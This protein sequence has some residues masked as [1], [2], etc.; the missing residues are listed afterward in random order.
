MRTGSSEETVNTFDTMEIR[1]SAF[2]QSVRTLPIPTISAFKDGNRIA[3]IKFAYADKQLFS[4]D[5]RAIAPQLPKI[6]AASYNYILVPDGKTNDHPTGLRVAAL[7]SGGPAAG[8][9]NVIVGLKDALGDKNTLLGVRNGP[10]GLLKG[11][12]FEIND[13]HIN[14]IRNTGGFD[15]LGTDRTKIKTPEQFSQLKT[16]CK[17]HAI[18]AI[19]IIGGDDSN[20]NAAFLAE[21]LFNSV[22]DDGS[23]VLVTGIPKTMDGDVQ[24]GDLLPISFGF[25]TATRIYAELVG[26]ILEDMAS[27]RKYWHFIKL[28]GRTA[29]H[30]TLEVALQTRP[31]LALIGE[32]IAEKELSLQDVVTTIAQVVIDRARNNMNYGVVLVPEGLLECVKDVSALIE[33]LDIAH[34]REERLLRPL[35]TENRKEEILKRLTPS[36]Q[37][38]FRSLPGYIQDMLVADRDSHGNLTVSQIQTER[39]LVDMVSAHLRAVAPDVKF[40]TN[41]H[42]FGY[43]GRCGAPTTFDSTLCYNLGLIAGSLVLDHRT[44][45]MAAVTSFTEGGVPLALPIAGMLDL[46]ER[47][48]KQEIV[49]QKTLVKTTDPAFRYFESR[50]DRWKEQDRFCSP[51]PRQLWGP[52]ARQVPMIVALNQGYRSIKY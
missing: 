2:E 37:T 11:D 15:L 20:T 51:G 50:R 42:F 13:E 23:G 25:S 30:V 35:D 10:K 28:M 29:S 27:S 21:Y 3:P 17:E 12:L 49:I 7:F 18:N 19:I 41:T 1:N 26:N 40:S 52:T 46:E 33:T 31:T 39:L 38:L 48:G 5:H 45:Y 36:D 24:R 9:H 44:G 34:A 43:E 32:E 47:E 4:K 22:H 14:A 16:I 6:V 8:G